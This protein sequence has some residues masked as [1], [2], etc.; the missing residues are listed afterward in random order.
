[1]KYLELNRTKKSAYQNQLAKVALREKLSFRYVYL[2]TRKIE[3]TVSK[4]S[5][6]ELE[7][8]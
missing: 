3:N 2:K 5:R 6:G 8:E 1:M 4:T 7:K